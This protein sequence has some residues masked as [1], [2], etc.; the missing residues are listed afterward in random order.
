MLFVQIQK[1]KLKKSR[2]QK[3]SLRGLRGRER[4]ARGKTCRGG[5]RGGGCN[6][7]RWLLCRKIQRRGLSIGCARMISSK[8]FPNHQ[9]GPSAALDPSTAYPHP[10]PRPQ[11][12]RRAQPPS[13]SHAQRA[14][15]LASL[16]FL[17]LMLWCTRVELTENQ[18]GGFNRQ[19][20]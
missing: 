13:L 3:I 6:H 18:R 20:R 19:W 15:Q 2:S 12:P 14:G 10:L 5:S 17:E 7:R 11:Q 16:T 4:Y 9:E 1:S 8:A